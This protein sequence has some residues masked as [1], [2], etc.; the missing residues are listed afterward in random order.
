ML[1]S[2]REGASAKVIKF[3]A[4]GF[5]LLGVSGM[6]FM[7]VGGFFRG[8]ITDTTLARVGRTT[9][10]IQA[11]ERTAQQAI[12]SQNM[13]M[14]EAYRFGLLQNILDEMIT[15]EAAKQEA[16]REG[17]VISQRDIA[18]RVHDFVKTQMQPGETPQKTLERLLSS[19]G[20][21]QDDLLASMR[22][23]QTQALMAD[24]MNAAVAFVPRLATEAM[25]RFQAERRD[26]VFMTLTPEVAGANLKADD[27]TLKTYFE[28]VKDQYQIPEQRVFRAIVLNAD[29]IKAG[30]SITDADVQAAYNERKDQFRIGE[31]RKIEQVVVPDENKAKEITQ[32]ARSN[33]SLKALAPAGTYRD[34]TEVEQASLPAEMAPVFA[35]NKGVVLNP[36]KTPLGWHIIKIIDIKPARAQ[37]FDE[38]KADLRKELESDALHNEMESRISK[39][40]EA[41]SQGD[42]LDTVATNMGL[43][44]KDV[45]PID[46]QG[47]FAP[48]EKSDPLLTALGQN[49][50][51]L[52]SL[53]E[54]MEGETS[55]L[56]E[57]NES[58]YA[59]FALNSVTP[60]RDREFAEVKPE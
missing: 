37:T 1:N 14:Q 52:S 32:A 48:T 40:D 12:R 26:I 6:I 49:K 43:T 18:N 59:V 30:I 8:G 28:T 31:R 10:S 44:V 29:D 50:D 15:R 17:I 16:V 24:P 33:T 56:A 55:D 41:V 38:V 58:M 46:S 23:S 57:I 34:I 4:L 11:F 19:Q 9:I 22:Q 20:L 2:L 7:D 25:G 21:T 45:G 42:T 13:T 51:L 60:T 47:T 5:V 36:I 53:F 27:E 35:G 3:L 39:I 54:L